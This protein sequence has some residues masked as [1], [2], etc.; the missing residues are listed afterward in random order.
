MPVGFVPGAGTAGAA[1]G[2]FRRAQTRETT[3]DDQQLAAQALVGAGRRR[4]PHLIVIGFALLHF[5]VG[6]FFLVPEL[7]LDI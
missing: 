6:Q 2:R 7:G 1:D 5:F 4:K 3:S